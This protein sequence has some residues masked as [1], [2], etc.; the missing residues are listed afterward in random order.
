MRGRRGRVINIV[1]CY[2][3]SQD[4]GSSICDSTAFIQQETILRK[5][6]ITESPWEHCINELIQFITKAILAGE[7]VI[8]SIDAN[9]PMHGPRNDVQKLLSPTGMVDAI[10]QFHGDETQRRI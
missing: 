10:A 7:E 1:T 3:V 2:Q 5:A 9:K 4:S 8:L 6:K